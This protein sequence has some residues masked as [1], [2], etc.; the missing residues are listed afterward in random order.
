MA[1]RT[2][3]LICY[4]VSEDKKRNKVVRELLKVGIRT[5]YSV[6]EAKLSENEL[7]TAIDKLENI[8]DIKTDSVIFY[9]LTAKEYKEIKRIGDKIIYLPIEDIFI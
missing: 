1:G 2:I 5:Q 7:E 4:D 3:Y 8:I 6:F 9:P